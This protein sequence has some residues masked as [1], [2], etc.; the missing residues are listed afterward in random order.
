MKKMTWVLAALFLA[1][2]GDE[3]GGG[4]GSGSVQAFVVAEETIPEGLTPGD[5]LENIQDGWTVTYDSFL[6][7]IGNFRAAR[8]GSGD[9]RISNDVYIVDMKSLPTNGFTIAEFDDIEAARWDRVGFDMPRAAA[10]TPCAPSVSADDCD[11]MRTHHFSVYFAATLTKPDGESCLRAAGGG[12]SDCVAA[13][14][15]SFVFGLSSGTSYDDCS[16][17]DDVPGFAVPSG[18]TVQ[19]KPTIHGD[20]WFFDN[21]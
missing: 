4:G 11:F 16:D 19:V 3:G 2:C 14:E 15:I 5:G 7:V 18:G 21:I 10:D 6:A 8:Q 17:E 9:Q 20:H 13:P 1:A 12:T